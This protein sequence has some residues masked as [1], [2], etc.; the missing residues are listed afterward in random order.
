MLAKALLTRVT[1]FLAVLVGLMAC[2]SITAQPIAFEGG[3]Q[4]VLTPNGQA[5]DAYIAQPHLSYDGRLLAFASKARNLLPGIPANVSD[6]AL[7]H[8]WYVLDRL[9]NRLERI[10]VNSNGEPHAGPAPPQPAVTSGLDISRDGRYVVFDSFAQNLTVATPIARSNVYLHDRQSK[11]TRLI[12]DGIGNAFAPMF[13][14]G[15]VQT[16]AYRCRSTTEMCFADT[17]TGNVR[18]VNLPTPYVNVR[19]NFSKNGRYLGC[20]ALGRDLGLDPTLAYAG[21]CD[22]QNGTVDF[23]YAMPEFFVNSASSIEFSADGRVAV[24]SIPSGPA[25]D[26]ALEDGVQVYV[27]R[28]ATRSLEIISRGRLNN[29]SQA[30]TFQGV[31]ISEDGRRVAFFDQDPNLALFQFDFFS[32]E[33]AVYVR[34]LDQDF[35]RYGA[36]LAFPPAGFPQHPGRPNCEL[37]PVNPPFGFYGTV[38]GSPNC[39]ELSGDGNTLAFSS[40]DWRWVPGDLNS[41]ESGCP[42]GPGFFCPRM[43]D[44]F[45]K[46]LLG[47]V[48][49]TQIPGSSWWQNTLMVLLLGLLGGAALRRDMR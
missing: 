32:A 13:V 43:L 45:V 42:Q 41:L 33:F 22:L 48:Q 46:S 25:F 28:E 17:K 16:V 49:V 34:D 30:Q 9:T 20:A 31:D 4:R 47:P 29:N 1:N 6:T 14:N 3:V 5:A 18:T 36:L 26:P 38:T 7:Y 12:S 21:R 37:T 40:H 39:P 35:N 8:Q 10:S 15:S 11:I 19:P 24:V 44:V 23:M 27:W 2:G